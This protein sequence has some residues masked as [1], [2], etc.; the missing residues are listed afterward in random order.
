MAGEQIVDYKIVLADLRAKRTAL[1][2]TIAGIEVILG[3][4]SGGFTSGGF[5]QDIEADSFVGM[6]IATA[7]AK[8]LKMVGR[9]ARTTEQVHDA[10]TR[11]GLPDFTRGSVATI[12][13]RI[14]NQGGDVV[15]VSKGVWGLAEWYPNRPKTKK[16]S[17]DEP[18]GEEQTTPTSTG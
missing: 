14:A 7:S 3:E 13:L 8:Y 4:S 10:L 5:S 2:Q 6:N 12:L 18:N 11:G 1:D 16:K 15:R 17:P 9:P